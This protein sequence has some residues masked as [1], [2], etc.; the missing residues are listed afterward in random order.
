MTIIWTRLALRDV[1]QLR[2]YIGRD[3]PGN[4]AVVAQLANGILHRHY[5]DETHTPD[6]HI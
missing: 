3:A 6:L 4:A 1:R 2:A 5:D